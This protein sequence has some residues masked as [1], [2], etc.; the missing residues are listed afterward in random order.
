MRLN[1]YFEVEEFVPP[2]I[3]KRYGSN[4][5][6]F[7]DP[8]II[9]L[10]TA[11]REFFGRPIIINDWHRKGKFSNRGFRLPDTKV[12][13]ELS[14]HKFGR[15]FDCNVSGLKVESVYEAILDNK[16]HFMKSGLTTLENI[17][18]T[19]TWIHSDVRYTGL[20]DILIVNP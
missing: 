6:W 3:F 18:F 4:S 12:G 20:N 7:I 2:S 8:K 1:D 15:A 16:E 9:Q 11:Y 19:E 10:A 17:N 13:G 14:Q 5:I